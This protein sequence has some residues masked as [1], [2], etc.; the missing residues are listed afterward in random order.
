MTDKT[1]SAAPAPRSLWGLIEDYA[2]AVSEYNSA[3]RID[4]GVDAAGKACIAAEAKIKAALTA[5]TPA[6]APATFRVNML[7]LAPSLSHE[8]IDQLAEQARQELSPVAG[9]PVAWQVRHRD[10]VSG[11]W[12][13]WE[14]DESTGEEP[15]FDPSRAE[16]RALY[17]APQAPAQA[18]AAAGGTAPEMADVPRRREESAE[19]TDERLGEIWG[20]LFKR[21]KFVGLYRTFARDVIAAD[22]EIRG[23]GMTP[24][25]TLSRDRVK[26]ICAAAGYGPNNV[27]A[28]AD[29]INGIR[30]GERA[31][32]IGLDA[33]AAHT[34]PWQPIETA[35]KEVEVLLWR[36]DAGAFTG[37]WTSPSTFIGADE[38]DVLEE[39]LLFGEAWFCGDFRTCFRADGSETPTHWM[40]LPA[41]PD[42]SVQVTQTGGQ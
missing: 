38:A 37:K 39:D 40:P 21:T 24:L 41:A 36:E 33:Q 34:S 11:Q 2:D 16:R 6:S 30:H 27:Q 14:P 31:H 13:D 17:T 35:P 4:V 29:F 5:A 28:R 10:I 1:P 9:E 26:S 7:R 15:P 22:R 8:Q 3:L 19:L 25:N 23:A 12:G 32:G 18:L 42:C 20:R